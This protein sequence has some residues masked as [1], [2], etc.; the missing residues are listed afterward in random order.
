[1]TLGRDARAQMDRESSRMLYVFHE[2]VGK[3]CLV[4]V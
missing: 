2:I 1:M 3:I 4:V